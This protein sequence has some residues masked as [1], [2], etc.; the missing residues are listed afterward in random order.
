MSKV[1]RNWSTAFLQGNP[2]YQLNM[3]ANATNNSVE[4]HFLDLVGLDIRTIRMLRLIG[5]NP[6]T[7]F[8]EISVM[9]A[10]ERSL[11]SR[12]IQSLVRGGLVE[13]RN[14]DS[15]ARRFGLYITAKGRQV[16]ARAD[17]LSRVGL[18]LLFDRIDPDEAAA[19]CRTMEKLA[20][21]IDS[22]E[23]GQEAERR[24]GQVRAEIADAEPAA[25][26]AAGTRARH[27]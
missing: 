17:A 19:F 22:D 26:A 24:F 10:L 7:T 13:R 12:L 27:G 5:D 1:L 18:E 16:R 6:G 21:W 9:G 23:Y 4:Q 2:V 11:T 3:L 14:D 20:T 15:D 25:Q 8:A